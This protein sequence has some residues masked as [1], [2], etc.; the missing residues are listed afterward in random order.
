MHYLNERVKTMLFCMTST[1][2]NEFRAAHKMPQVDDQLILR[3]ASGDRDAFAELYHRTDSAIYGFILSILKNRHDA[4]DVMQDT[5]LNISMGAV[6]YKAQGKPMAW[7]LTIA[8][9][10][11]RMKLREQ[12]HASPTDLSELEFAVPPDSSSEDRAV[13]EAVLKLLTNEERQIVMLHAVAG[14]KHRETAD[15]LELPLAT[16][17][18]KYRR[19]L[20]KLKW[21]LEE[22][23]AER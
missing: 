11:A 9:N 17:L 22:K 14:L 5:Y 16:V 2:Q 3:V 6:A 18:S 12:K 21:G 8:R 23:E 10:L 19:A 1:M 7:I 4:E 20:K 13:L 15:L